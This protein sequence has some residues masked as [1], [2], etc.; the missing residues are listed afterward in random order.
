MNARTPIDALERE[1]ARCVACA[2]RSS[3]HGPRAQRAITAT[4]DDQWWLTHANIGTASAITGVPT[5]TQ[6]ATVSTIDCATA[7]SVPGTTPTKYPKAIPHA[8]TKDSGTTTVRIASVK[9]IGPSTM[10]IMSHP[11]TRHAWASCSSAW[12]Q[13]PAPASVRGP[14]G[15]WRR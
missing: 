6:N 9:P 13:R 5:S 15:S 12:L 11:S 4:R 2:T 1:I 8:A 3:A 14:P 7:S 10:R